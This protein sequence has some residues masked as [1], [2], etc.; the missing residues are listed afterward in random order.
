MAKRLGPI[1]P[2]LFLRSSTRYF[3]K[4]IN[5]KADVKLFNCT[6]GGIYLDGFKHISL[7][8]FIDSEINDTKTSDCIN[9]IFASVVRDQNKYIKDKTKLTRFI[10]DNIKLGKEVQRLS[11]IAIDIA[12]KQ[13]QTD[14]DLRR[15]DLVQN[16]TIKKLTKNISIPWDFRKKFTFLKLA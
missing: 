8:S 11:K 5:K 12:T 6:E 1:L 14:E 10:K 7:K 2:F 15:F 4:S 3:A 13:Y 9:S 16:K